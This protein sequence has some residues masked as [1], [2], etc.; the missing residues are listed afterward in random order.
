MDTINSVVGW[1]NDSLSWVLIVLVILA[2]I[3]FTLLTRA[4]QLRHFRTM[5]R[6][7]LDS[8]TGAGDGISSFQAFCISLA[9]RVGTGNIAGVAIALALGGPGAIFWMWLM[10]SLGMAT[11]FVEATLA[12][13]YKVPHHDRSFRGGPAYYMQRGLKS[14]PMGILFAVLL[15]FTFGFV[16]Q[17][18]QANTIAA[19]F[20]KSFSISPYVTAALLAV[21][22]GAVVLGG[23]KKVAKVTEWMAPIMA[24]IYVLLATAIIVMNLGEVPHAIATIVKGAFGLDQTLAG[25]G[26]GLLAT[27]LNGVKRGMYSNEAGM[28]SAPNAAA[29]A[30]T[31]HPVH[32]GLIQSLGVFVDTMMVCTTT[33]VVILLS[34]ASVYTPGI[35]TKAMAG[36]TLTQDAMAYSLG[37]WVG[38]VFTLLVFVFAFST[39]LGNE[40]YAEINMDFMRGGRVGELAIRIM[41]IASTA[42]GAVLALD[43]VW[44]LADIAMALMAVTNLVSLVFLGK[45]AVAALRDFESQ[46]DPVTAQFNLDDNRF[47][48][49][50]IPGEVWHKR[51]GHEAGKWFHPSG[52]DS[53]SAT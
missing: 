11:A 2:G 29:A 37:S 48:Q 3:T 24:L 7:A 16:F 19:V 12:Q 14:R 25:V 8:R 46:P 36:A 17:M 21:A 44:S 30:T 22:V 26:G 9:S 20:E 38:P 43:L 1:L 49:D 52:E 47:M 34:D 13:L 5:L 45:Y 51:P 31:S 23:V 28:G 50:D 41:T 27:V 4:M 18:V 40:T 33:A 53:L 39:L 6:V 10:A 32:Q 35:T 42:L 15:V